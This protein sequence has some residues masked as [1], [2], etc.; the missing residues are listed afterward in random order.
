MHTHTVGGIHRVET[1]LG[2]FNTSVR[3]TATKKVQHCNSNNKCN[4]AIRGPKRTGRRGYRG[5]ILDTIS[6]TLQQCYY[7]YDTISHLPLGWPIVSI[8]LDVT[9]VHLRLRGTT[10]HTNRKKTK[11]RVGGCPCLPSLE[12]VSLASA[13]SPEKAQALV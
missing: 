2:K 13:Y 1:Y 5:L 10:L 6:P 11:T 3:S 9:T 12:L 4:G 7:R 8:S